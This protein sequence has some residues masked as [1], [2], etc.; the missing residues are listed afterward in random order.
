VIE[1]VKAH[2]RGGDREDWK[3]SGGEQLL[4]S[5]GEERQNDLGRGEKDLYN[6]NILLRKE[7][8]IGSFL[9]GEGMS[10]TGEGPWQKGG[11]LWMSTCHVWGKNSQCNKVWDHGGGKRKDGNKWRKNSQKGGGTS[12]V[13]IRNELL[14]KMPM[15][16]MLRECSKEKARKNEELSHPEGGRGLEL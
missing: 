16:H 13:R 10:S 5:M 8:L 15:L 12:P 6:C 3:T 14:M 11:G 1:K 7:D 9:W 4:E 2:R